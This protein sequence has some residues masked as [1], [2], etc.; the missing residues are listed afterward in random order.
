MD[1]IIYD[2]TKVEGLVVN[3]KFYIIAILGSKAGR[4]PQVN[5]I[6]KDESETTAI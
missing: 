6:R 1:L 3:S 2:F 5:N 4:T